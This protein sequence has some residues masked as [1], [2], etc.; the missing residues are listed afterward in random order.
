MNAIEQDEIRTLNHQGSL[1]SH[2]RVPRLPRFLVQGQ[3]E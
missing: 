2:E 1:S 3:V